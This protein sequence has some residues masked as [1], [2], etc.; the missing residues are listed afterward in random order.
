MQTRI[1]FQ[2]KGPPV[3][4][5]VR[6]LPL[7]S[8]GGRTVVGDSRMASRRLDLQRQQELEALIREAME[9][10]R[11]TMELYCKFE[12]MFSRPEELRS[13]WFD[14]AQHESRHFGALA[15]VA[16]LLRGRS[17]RPLNLQG[18][19]HPE[20]LEHLRE[21][22]RSAHREV[23]RGVT[24]A[25]AFAIALEI[26]SSE[27]ED[28]VLE[29]IH[30]LRGDAEREKAVQLLLHDLGDLAYMVEKYARDPSLL[31]RADALLESQVERLRKRVSEPERQRPSA[32]RKRSLR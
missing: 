16:G 19:L 10:E 21:C 5:L 28:V 14:M 18:H 8:V 1:D 29:L 24:L 25:R 7:P 13:F 12:S 30:E 32:T 9:L 26:E 15:L 4:G 20:R 22:L 23:D 11:Q 31:A 2:R 6:F 27:I 17:A 3:S